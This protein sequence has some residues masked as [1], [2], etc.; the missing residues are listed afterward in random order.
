MGFLILH[1]KLNVIKKNFKVLVLN[2][3]VEISINI[4]LSY[5]HVS[6]LKISDKLSRKYLSFSDGGLWSA[7]QSLFQVF[8]EIS[9]KIISKSSETC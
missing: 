8:I 5:L 9:I 6:L 7:T 2:S 3:E 4:M 1:F